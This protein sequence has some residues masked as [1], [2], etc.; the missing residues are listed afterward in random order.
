MKRLRKKPVSFQLHSAVTA[1]LDKGSPLLKIPQ[2]DVELEQF[3]CE[4][5]VFPVPEIYFR[6][7]FDEMKEACLQQARDHGLVQ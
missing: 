5:H 3:A 4:F 1:I 7:A 2:E 6:E